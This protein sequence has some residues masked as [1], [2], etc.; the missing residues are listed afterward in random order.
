M[1][2][3]AGELQPLGSQ[4]TSIAVD[5]FTK[6]LKNSVPTAMIPIDIHKCLVYTANCILDV[7]KESGVELSEI[8]IGRDCMP[9]WPCCFWDE[10]VETL[11]ETIQ[12][13]LVVSQMVRSLGDFVRL[14]IINKG[15]MKLDEAR[16]QGISLQSVYIGRG[17]LPAWPVQAKQDVDLAIEGAFEVQD[18]S[19]NSDTD[20]GS[21]AEGYKTDGS[22][23]T[24]T[25]ATQLTPLAAQFKQADLSCSDSDGD[26][27]GSDDDYDQVIYMNN[28]VC[29]EP[30]YEDIDDVNIA[31]NVDVVDHSQ[32]VDMQVFLVED[33]EDIAHVPMAEL[34][35]DYDGYEYYC[36]DSGD[37]AIDIEL[38][39]GELY[40]FVGREKSDEEGEEDEQEEAM[41]MSDGQL[42][43]DSQHDDVGDS[44]ED[45]TATTTDDDSSLSEGSE[46]DTSIED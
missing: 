40:C 13:G 35:V 26:D 9:T 14:E 4:A 41:P 43:S 18:E 2:D 34:A 7:A 20:G 22:D 16:K 31:H 1:S 3:M 32:M 28:F 12:K 23:E 38:Q 10:R 27:A 29:P 17:L 30:I 45:G 11:H 39:D 33:D 21:D 24:V 25:E 5:E 15:N 44:D 46:S 19:Y 36:G 8:T 42:S 37:E 6:F